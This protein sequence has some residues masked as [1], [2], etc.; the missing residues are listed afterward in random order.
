MYENIINRFNN[1]L[2]AADIEYRADPFLDGMRWTFAKFPGAD[3]AVNN[4]ECVESYGFPFDNG[5]ITVTS[6]EE[7][8]VNILE[9]LILIKSFPENKPFI[10]VSAGW[11]GWFAV[12]CTW[13]EEINGYTMWLSGVGRY[14]NK[15]EAVREAR[16]WAEDEG[17]HCDC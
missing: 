9:E 4:E 6:P 11:G 10:T 5:D 7:M 15:A 14:K 1:A 17:V 16:M 3:V 13:D 2:A 8:C 12:M